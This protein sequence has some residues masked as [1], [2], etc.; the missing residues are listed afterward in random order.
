MTRILFSF[1]SSPPYLTWKRLVCYGGQIAWHSSCWVM[2]SPP[3]PPQLPW[4]QTFHIVEA[5]HFTHEGR[6]D[7]YHCY[8]TKAK[9]LQ[10]HQLSIRKAG[11]FWLVQVSLNPAGCRGDDCRDS[12]KTLRNIIR[13]RKSFSFGPSCFTFE[14]EVHQGKKLWI[15]EWKQN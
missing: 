3:P 11:L 12:F 6:Y 5:P 9:N 4:D 8:V 7:T 2:E 14:T 10:G 15:A 13:N 1:L